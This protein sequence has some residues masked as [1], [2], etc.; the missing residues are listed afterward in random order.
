MNS[1]VRILIALCLLLLLCDAGYAQEYTWHFD[2]ARNVLHWK[3]IDASMEQGPSGSVI[4]RGNDTFWFA[5]P[6]NLNIPSRVSY[7]EFKLK[8]PVTYLMGY[9]IMRT[10]DNRTWQADFQLGIP[11]RFDVYSVN[12]QKGNA[13]NAPVDAF[14]FAFGGLDKVELQYVRCYEPSFIELAGIYW[15]EFWNAS[16]AK[17]TSVNFIDAPFV[18]NISFLTLLYVFLILFVVCMTAVLRPVNAGAI[19]KAVVIS[20]VAAGI[21]FALRMDYTWYMMWRLDSASLSHKSL[22]ERVFLVDGTGAYEFA[23]EVKKIVP[24]GENV[25]IYGGDVAVKL[26]YYLLPLKVSDNGKYIAVCKGSTLT[27]DSVRKVLRGV[28]AVIA[29]NVS[30]IKVFKEDFSLYR[31][32][33]AVQG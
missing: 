28:D 12:I 11:D 9:L 18:G 24:M 25:R 3:A 16:Y 33:G 15:G 32:D 21:L 23:E 22:D 14:A 10:A 13:G 6:P 8:A 17:A 7:V 4:I 30:L 2:D 1:R 26:K 20:F 5:S 29:N 31:I 27:Y 19:T